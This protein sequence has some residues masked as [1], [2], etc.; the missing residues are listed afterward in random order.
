MSIVDPVTCGFAKV[1][2]TNCSQKMVMVQWLITIRIYIKGIVIIALKLFMAL[3]SY[4]GKEI[5]LVD[6]RFILFI[7][8]II[9]DEPFT[10]TTLGIL[11]L[12]S[13]IFLL[14]I[15]FLTQMDKKY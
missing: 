8:V 3:V 14:Y 2:S 5:L 11:R 15:M 13:I 7:V 10:I 4:D 6:F 9:L 1:L 12:F